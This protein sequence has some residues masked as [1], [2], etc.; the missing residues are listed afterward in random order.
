VKVAKENCE[1]NGVLNVTCRQSDLI[2]SATGKYDFISANIVADIIIR[3]ADNVGD[4]LA[5]DG[6]LVVSGI[7]ESQAEQVVSVFTAKGF[8]LVDKLD[9]NDWNAFVFKKKV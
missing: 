9:K 4:F 3:M 2:R 7:I 5:S 6:I 8:M 1:Q